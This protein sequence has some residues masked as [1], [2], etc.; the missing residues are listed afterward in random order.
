MAINVITKPSKLPVELADIKAHLRVTSNDEDG[1]IA[2]LIEAATNIAQDEMNRALITQTIE[3][4]LP[5]F[6]TGSTIE[7]ERAPVQSVSSIQYYDTDNNLQTYSSTNYE[8]YT[9]LT[10]ARI[11]LLNTASWPSTYA[12]D[13]A[14]IITYVAG[15]GN[16]QDDVPQDI[17]LAIRALVEHYYEHRGIMEAVPNVTLKNIPKSFDY[18]TLKYKV[19]HV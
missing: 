3:E 12:K 8:V 16:D 4:Y 2:D 19:H 10:P 13:K 14:V 18:I 5:R 17:K 6:P 11:A 7:L 1:Y 9:E 15:Y